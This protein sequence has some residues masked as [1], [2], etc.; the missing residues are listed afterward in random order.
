[1]NIR[2]LLFLRWKSFVRHT[3]V[4]QM[5][6]LRLLIG[7]YAILFLTVLY[8]SGSLLQQFFIRLIPD[9]TNSF[10]LFIYT[11]LALLII[12]LVIKFLFKKSDKSQYNSFLRFYNSKRIIKIYIILKEFVSLW[13]FYLLIFFFS[14]LTVQI[15]P[16]WGIDI[17]II[18]FI[19]LYIFQFFISIWI[20]KI[21]ENKDYS[22][23]TIYLLGKNIELKNSIANYILLNIR[24]TLR[25]PKLCKQLLI[26]ILL[27]GAY[28][29]LF[30]RAENEFFGMSL[31]LIS[32]IFL[33]FPLGLNQ[34]LFSSEA[35]Y[36]D[37]LMIL[38]LFKQILKAKY[39]YY[40]F[41]SIFLLIT[42]LFIIQ[43]LNWLSIMELLAIFFY[44]SGTVTLA[45]FCV[46]LFANTKIDLFGSPSKMI[47]AS[48]T[49]Q[50]LAS[51]L[52][53]GIF[54][55]FVWILSIMLSKEFAIYFMLLTG[56]ASILCSN[57][58][59][60]YLY[61]C[62]NATKYEKMEIFRI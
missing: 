1:M 56:I 20:N 7:L 3:L 47:M 32:F 15:Y 52:I 53:Y 14:F 23:N 28:I 43:S 27:T 45:S 24:M 44:C 34:F 10:I 31:F 57:L 61:R 9:Q 37:Q 50:S 42:L 33:L 51:I 6:T 35:A 8:L 40:L 49:A 55:G 2:T 17:T 25:S 39:I 19:F 4:E 59:F 5:I 46:I 29:Y 22:F 54:I 36:F 13:N 16:V 18:S 58:W 41:F 62:F 30:Q 60:N 11:A 21:K 26:L 12:D 38:P 48:P